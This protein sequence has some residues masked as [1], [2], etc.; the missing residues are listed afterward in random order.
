MHVTPNFCQI[1]VRSLPEQW[2]ITDNQQASSVGR[3]WH[4]SPRN[5]FATPLPRREKWSFPLLQLPSQQ[6]TPR[7]LSRSLC[8]FY[9]RRLC[10]AANRRNT[11]DLCFCEYDSFVPVLECIFPWMK[12]IQNCLTIKCFVEYKYE[13]HCH[14]TPSSL[15]V[16]CNSGINIRWKSYFVQNYNNKIPNK[17]PV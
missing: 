7:F 9:M 17:I 8:S 13:R 16:I 15:I 10:I 2:I 3:I 6:R 4:L 12:Q 1:G 11:N 14:W 5:S